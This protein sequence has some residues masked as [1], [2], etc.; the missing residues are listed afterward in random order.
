MVPLRPRQTARPLS[1][2]L[3]LSS[4][5]PVPIKS[6][7]T[8][9]EPWA[10]AL[11]PRQAAFGASG[12]HHGQSRSHRALLGPSYRQAWGRV[13]KQTWEHHEQS[14]G[15]LVGCLKAIMQS[16]GYLATFD[17][18]DSRRWIVRPSARRCAGQE[19]AHLILLRISRRERQPL[20]STSATA[21]PS[22]ILPRRRPRGCLRA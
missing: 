3:S 7:K 5:A 13:H 10:V 4:P 22:C 20:V 8:F 21:G 16:L 2:S 11:M 6:L 18:Q 1:L 15:H 9:P 19:G 12:P 17:D 14:W